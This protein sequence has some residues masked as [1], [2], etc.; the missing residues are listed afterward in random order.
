M[1][2]FTVYGILAI[3]YAC[4]GYA[5]EINQICN[6]ITGNFACSV[7]ITLPTTAETK[8][9]PNKFFE[10]DPC[11]TRATY[12]YPCPTW[13]KPG[14]MC[15]GWTCVPGTREKWIDVPCGINI[16][17]I[18]VGLCDAVQSE[19]R[20][21]LDLL[22]KAAAMCDCIPKVLALSTDGSLKATDAVSDVSSATSGVLVVY[23]ELQKI[24][25]TTYIRFAGAL[26]TCI[27]GCDVNAIKSFFFD[28]IQQSQEEL[29]NQLRGIMDP[30]TASFGEMRGTLETLE[31]SVQTITNSA[32]DVQSKIS[33]IGAPACGDATG[34]AESTLSQFNDQGSWMVFDRM[35][36]T[37]TDRFL[38]AQTIQLQLSLLQDTITVSDAVSTISSMSTLVKNAEEAAS[39]PLT[40]EE[41]ISI[42]TEGRIKKLV[43]IVQVFKFPGDLRKLIDDLRNNIPSISQFSKVLDTRTQAISG[44]ITDVVSDSWLQ[45]VD[46]SGDAARAVRQNIAMIQEEFR[47]KVLPAIADLQTKIKSI[48]GMLSALPF[49]AKPPSIDAKVASYQ[50]WSRIAINMPCSRWAT[51]EYSVPGYTDSFKYPQFY[52][53]PL[54]TPVPWPNHHIPYIK[55]AFQ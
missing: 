44:N 16:K 20:V 26:G 48:T 17:S 40:E 11:K 52:N 3:S 29:S 7:K 10:T 41:I 30:W 4:M 9:C 51:K 5:E 2:H 13:R 19:L 23:A 15:D 36:T 18:D 53:C 49:S 42:I 1:H 12:R 43:D 50:R 32:R 24:D 6:A 31:A 14:R 46:V 54:D 28:Y 39:I 47:A 21:N 27:A 55:I 35:Y 33:T 38:V 8:Y 34:C 37:W 22:N 45:Q 25:L